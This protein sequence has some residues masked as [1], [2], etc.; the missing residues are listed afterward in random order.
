MV[1]HKDFV[2]PKET[3]DIVTNDHI[4]K[5]TEDLNMKI[6]IHT[7][8]LQKSGIEIEPI[9]LFALSKEELIDYTE[10]LRV[11]FDEFGYYKPDHSILCQIE[12][13]KS[14]RQKLTR[15]RLAKRGI[16]MDCKFDDP[17]V[18]EFIKKNY[19]QKS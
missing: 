12:G 9:S 17:L 8:L 7:V 10:K 1:K 5:I 6:P 13:R 14:D 15:K 18:I 2:L 16:F 3:I 4:F 11:K 19:L